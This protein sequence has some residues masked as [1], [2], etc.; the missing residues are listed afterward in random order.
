MNELCRVNAKGPSFNESRNLQQP[1]KSPSI[2]QQKSLKDNRPHYV[3]TCK[4]I[5]AI[6]ERKNERTL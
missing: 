4:K 6:V 3:E 5:V 2:I 1:A